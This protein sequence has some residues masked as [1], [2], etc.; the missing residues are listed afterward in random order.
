MVTKNCLVSSIRQI[1]GQPNNEMHSYL[2]QLESK[3]WQNFYYGVNFP[4]IIV[5]WVCQ[6]LRITFCFVIYNHFYFFCLF[7]LPSSFIMVVWPNDV[8]FSV[9]FRCLAIFFTSLLVYVLQETEPDF[10]HC[11]VCIEGYQLND[12]VRILPCK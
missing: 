2:E 3:W 4:F 12:V 10:N 1:F 9:L 7:C 8:M 11:A 6:V 5:R